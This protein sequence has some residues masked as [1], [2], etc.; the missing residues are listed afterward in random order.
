MP[1]LMDDPNW[2]NFGG[3]TT[4]VCLQCGY[5][6]PIDNRKSPTETPG[7]PDCGFASADILT[8]CKAPDWDM[9]EELISARIEIEIFASGP[10]A[11]FKTHWVKD[12][13]DE[14]LRVFIDHDLDTVSRLRGAPASEYM[15]MAPGAPDAPGGRPDGPDTDLARRVREFLD[16]LRS[17]DGRGRANKVRG[18]MIPF[19]G[20]EHRN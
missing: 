19:D 10:E 5:R 4:R 17:V 16:G 3:D 8:E 14:R 13:V 1:G 12:K 7:C 18:L 9:D 15:G 2:Q 11:L 6:W 20:D